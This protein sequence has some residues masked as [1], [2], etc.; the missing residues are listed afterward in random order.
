[1]NWDSER[2]SGDESE[3]QNSGV[4]VLQLSPVHF[5]A[6]LVQPAVVTDS[7]HLTRLFS[8]IGP[9]IMIVILIILILAFF[10]LNYSR[11]KQF[12]SRRK[13]HYFHPYLINTNGSTIRPYITRSPDVSPQTYFLTKPSY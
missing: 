6:G 5:V 3:H 2:S 7:R 10:Y 12:Y 4:Q 1:M 13:T 11:I 9:L 8:I